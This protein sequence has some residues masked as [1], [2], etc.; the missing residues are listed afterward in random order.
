MRDNLLSVQKK[1]LDIVSKYFL[2]KNSPFLRR[3]YFALYT[4]DEGNQYIK[5]RVFKYKIN[6]INKIKK[7]LSN[8]IR[9]FNYSNLK[10]ISNCRDKKYYN[11]LIITWGNNTSF[12]SNGSFYDKYLSTHTLAHKNTFWIIL[13]DN[14][15][16]KKKL[17]NNIATIYPHKSLVNY[18]KF[19]QIYIL[20]LAYTIF[21][22]NKNID[23]DYLI[24]ECINNFIQKKKSLSKLTNLLMPYEGQIFQKRIFFKQ[25]NQNK[26]LITYGFDHSAP[27]SIATQLYYTLG[28]PDILL[29]SGLNVK[30][31]YSKFYNWSPN[32]IK[33]SFPT[34]YKNFN[35]KNFLSKLF[36]PYDF[37]SSK[38]IIENIDFFLRNKE[39]KSI[40][41]FSVNIHPAKKNNNKH[42]IL[43]KKIENIKKK[44][45]R[46]FSNKSSN[47]ITITVGFT[48]T[49]IVALEFNLDVLHI[50]PN[51]E[52]DT[53][54]NYFWPDIII[55]RINKFCFLY[56]LKKT[57]SYLNFKNENKV[58][59]LINDKKIK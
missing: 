3:S 23:Q 59:E 36:L 22:K 45:E 40:K 33:L 42:I 49:P 18:Y 24:S 55:K 37:T 39:N 14:K 6:T 38:T 8:N 15:I 53:Y 7:I 21:G 52:F 30:K 48:T 32:K 29:V 4:N 41:K 19:L 9:I 54:L 20:N 1:V 12:F 34:R 2:K 47:D 56:R 13:S 58:L 26:N 11:N 16:E 35:K 5:D 50:C 27:H 46:K 28:S 57:G 10:I 44:Y 25:K 17:D 51:P 31:C 43:K